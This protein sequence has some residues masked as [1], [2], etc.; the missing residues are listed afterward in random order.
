M[1]LPPERL[2][3]SWFVALLEDA[4]FG[5]NVEL[6]P[7]VMYSGAESLDELVENMVLVKEVFWKGYSDGELEMAKMVFREEL[8]KL[9][10]FEENE[11]VVRFEMK[12]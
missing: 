8:R 5:N 4:G 7:C 3:G 12:A 1:A 6:R 11:G 10:T 9:R 2:R